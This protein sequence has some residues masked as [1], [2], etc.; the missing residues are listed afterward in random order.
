MR[1]IVVVD[2]KLALADTLADGLVDRGYAAR[3]FGKSREAL[4]VIEREPIDLVVTDLRMPELDGLALLD[5]ARRRNIPVIVMTGHGAIDSA[6]EALRK[7]AFHYLTKPF[8]LDE[9]VEFVERALRERAVP[10]TI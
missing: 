5:A 9:L 4:A 7:G 1:Q 2:D 8:K 6:L 10:L 3:A